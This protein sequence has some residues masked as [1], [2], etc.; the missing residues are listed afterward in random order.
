MIT[1]ISFILYFGSSLILFWILTFSNS[2]ISLSFKLNWFFKLIISSFSF[3]NS[4]LFIWLFCIPDIILFDLN[5]SSFNFWLSFLYFSNSFFNLLISFLLLFNSSFNFLFSSSNFLILKT[6]SFDLSSNFLFLGISS[7]GL[8]CKFLIL[9]I[10]SFDLFCSSLL[11]FLYFWIKSVN[12]FD[13]YYKIKR[14]IN[15]QTKKYKII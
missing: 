5:N 15:I 4:L 12:V 11:F 7:F 8:F 9:L 2:F 6:S 10:S 1:I 13:W 14:I 3:F